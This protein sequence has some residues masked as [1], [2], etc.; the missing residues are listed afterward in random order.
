M[1]DRNAIF[2]IRVASLTKTHIL[3]R[4]AFWK[5]SQRQA[6]SHVRKMCCFSKAERQFQKYYNTELIMNCEQSFCSV[7]VCTTCV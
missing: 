2:S 3:R 7:L 6:R 1:S 5:L 4:I